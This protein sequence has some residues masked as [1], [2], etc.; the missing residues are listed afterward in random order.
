MEP[1]H[2]LSG[3][4]DGSRHGER[5]KLDS[6][7]SRLWSGSRTIPII[8]TISIPNRIG[9]FETFKPS[10]SVEHR[11]KGHPSHVARW[12]GSWT[13]AWRCWPG[14]ATDPPGPMPSRTPFH[15]ISVN[16]N[17]F[18]TTY[19]L[20]LFSISADTCVRSAW[21]GSISGKQLI[22]PVMPPGRQNRSL[23]QSRFFGPSAAQSINV[24]ENASCNCDQCHTYTFKENGR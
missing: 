22:P 18:H 6:Y 19:S 1:F 8:P 15:Q 3:T 13:C 17:I 20:L 5:D 11:T 24:D 23:R 10:I 16:L 7:K 4:L 14:A 2:N 9:W 21:T 12:R